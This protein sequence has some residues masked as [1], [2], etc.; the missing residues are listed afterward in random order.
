MNGLTDLAR[1]LGK[2]AANVPH[3]AQDVIHQSII[4]IEQAAPPGAATDV[5]SSITEGLGQISGP[6]AANVHDILD[7]AQDNIAT[8]AVDLIRRGR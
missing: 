4:A 3:S 5:T 1:D 8:A 7:R 6:I 2:A